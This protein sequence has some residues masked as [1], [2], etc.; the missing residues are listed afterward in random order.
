MVKLS[1]VIPYYKTY[2]LTIRMINGLI[3]QLTDEVEVILVDD[4]CNETVLDMYE[5]D[6]KVIHLKE[7]GG[8]SKA[9]NTGIQEAQGKYIAFIDSDDMIT[10]DYVEQLLKVIDER[11]E[12]IIIFN[13]LD[14]TLNSL[15]VKPTNCAVW[16][17][18]YKKDIIPMFNEELRVKEDYFWQ[19]ELNKQKLS[20]YYLNRVL[21]MYNSNREGSL[22]W[23]ETN[24]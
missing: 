17:A 2:D 6:I 11:T 9:R 8:V 19:K 4:G 5:K 23:N 20:I 24:K 15:N 22:W 10:M 14:T 1:I 7:N 16:K 12:D 13:W 3:P 21:Y 18:I